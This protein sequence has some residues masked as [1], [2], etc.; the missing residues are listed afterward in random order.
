VCFVVFAMFNAGS[1]VLQW[2][3]PSELFPTEVRA[4]AVG[5]ATSVSRIGAAAGTFLFPIGLERLGVCT[6]LLMVAGLC[7]VGWLASLAWA[8]ETR[9]M[10]LLEASSS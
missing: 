3:Y 8:P 2:V 5:F 9:G 10:S 1:S 7:V 4:S 6:V